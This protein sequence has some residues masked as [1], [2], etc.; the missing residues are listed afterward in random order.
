M[1][2]SFAFAD[3]IVGILLDSQLDDEK[4]KEIKSLLEER[5]KTNDFIS[6]YFED[7]C[8]Q[9]ISLVAYLKS[10]LFHYTHPDSIQKVAIVTDLKWFQ[11]SMDAK[12]LMVEANLKT[13]DISQRIEAMNW[14]MQ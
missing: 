7:E 10:L 8:R 14:V 12:D 5:L 6:I 3:N 11:K 13:F 1:K 2:N 4:I 9:G